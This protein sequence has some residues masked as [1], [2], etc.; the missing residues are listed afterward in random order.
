MC[1]FFT[2]ICAI[3]YLGFRIFEDAL[4]SVTVA[5]CAAL[6][7]SQREHVCKYQPLKSLTQHKHVNMG[8]YM[9]GHISIIFQ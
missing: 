5:V 1:F 4:L 3:H 6:L 2:L 7:P 8:L 9:L